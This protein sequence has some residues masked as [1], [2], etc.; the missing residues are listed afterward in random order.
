MVVVLEIIAVGHT[1]YDSKIA[2]SLAW[3]IRS[4]YWGGN[5]RGSQDGSQ[6]GDHIASCR[7][8]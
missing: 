7:S 6:H 4:K 3:L 1:W 8:L 2:Q 5:G